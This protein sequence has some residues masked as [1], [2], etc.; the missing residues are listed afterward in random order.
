MGGGNER[1]HGVVAAGDP[2]TARAGASMLERGGSA[3]DAAVASAFAAF[4]CEMPLCSPLGGGVLVVQRAGEEALAIDLFARTPGLG[5]ERG[6][7]LDFEGIE[8]SFGAATQVFHVGR[9]SAAMPL[10]LQGLVDVH[11]RWGTLPLAEIVAPAIALAREGYVLGP[12]VAFVFQVL[13]PIVARTAECLA[14]YTDPAT[15]ALAKTGAR[16]WNRDLGDTLETIAARP[17]SIDDLFA[18]LVRE[19]AP[20]AGG[21]VTER[22]LREAAIAITTPARVR[23]RGWELATMPGPSTGGALVALG[24]RLLDGVGATGFLSREHLLRFA[25]VQEILLAER[26]GCHGDRFLDEERI[27]SLRARLD[28][29]DAAE[30]ENKLG[31]TTHISVI[32]EHGS[33]VSLTLTN[34]EGSGHVLPRTGMIINNLLGEEDL[35]PRGFHV[36]PPG[37]ALS[38]MMAPTLLRRGDDHVALGS[39]GSNRLRNAI[40]GVVSAIVEH[41]IDPATAVRAPRLHLEI[42]AGS[43]AP[44]IA[45]E[46]AGLAPDVVRALADAYPASPAIFDAP[47][48]YFGGVHL[49]RAD[50]H[51]F[52]GVGDPRRG[53]AFAVA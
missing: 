37:S 22:D 3:I 38:T 30:P 43:R 7:E 5:A 53:G 16:L 44:R 48:L 47:N 46:A 6:G 36:D 12:G 28:R 29:G 25:R 40:L 23:H 31:S 52:T 50:G 26:H 19:L 24:L 33:A 49:A 32:D 35:H 34:G 15:G 8:V 11:R 41:E 51:A 27:A 42:D 20:R 1:T 17:A 21:L 18:A 10:A 39:G 14:L 45:F 4:V 9:G 13:A 2:Q